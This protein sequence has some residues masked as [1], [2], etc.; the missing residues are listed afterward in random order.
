MIDNSKESFRE[1]VLFHTHG[2]GRIDFSS[3]SPEDLFEI[4]HIAFN[5]SL[6]LCPTVFLLRNNMR[7]FRSLLE[8]FSEM[9]TTKK[10]SRILGF[11]LE[12]PLLCQNGGTP[13]GSIWTPVKDEW[14]EIIS[15]FNFGLKYIVISPDLI[16]LEE[17]VS[18]DFTF[19][20]LIDLIYDSGG[21]IALGHFSHNFPAQS[22]NRILEILDHLESKYTSSPYLV[23]TDHFLNDMPRNFKHA[24]RTDEELI[25]RDIQISRFLNTTWEDHLLNNLLGPVPATLLKAAKDKRLALALNFDGLHVDL[26]ICKRIVQYLGQSNIIAI[27]DHTET[28]SILGEL[29]SSTICQ[30]LLYQSDGILAASATTHEQQLNNMLG[31]GIEYKDIEAMFYSNPLNALSYVPIRKS[32]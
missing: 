22:A 4:D 13:R 31:I 2:I 10:I 11:S 29:L 30:G 14:I 26:A 12:G 25:N 28:R 1:I 19:A 23:L 20:N 15:W 21:R 18:S 6:Y 5:R 9:S 16:S 27:T 3:M 7:A 8:N 32:C 17:E 24:F